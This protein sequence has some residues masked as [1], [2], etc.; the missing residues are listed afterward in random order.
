[1]ADE[2]DFD[3]A[4]GLARRLKT[5]PGLTWDDD[6]V[7]AHQQLLMRWCK[8]A[9]ID[10]HSVWPAEAQAEWLVM[11][12]LETWTKWQ[13]SAVLYQ[14]FKSKFD[15][16][17]PLLPPANAA[18]DL[19]EKP[20]I[21]CFTCKDSGIVGGPGEKRYCSCTMGRSLEGDTQL[22]EKWLALINSGG[23]Q[24]KAKPVAPAIDEKTFQIAQMRRHAELQLAKATLENPA[25]TTE[26]KE[27]AR[28]VIKVYTAAPPKK[29]ARAR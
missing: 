18:Q 2:L 22:G 15:P 13:G 7:F 28:E 23:R 11:T 10:G 20:P 3:I 17:L 16:P 8:G 21:E 5:I 6:V 1:M 29:K 4:M 14:L 12:A 19:G 24:L 25:A 27:I 9:I 26:Q